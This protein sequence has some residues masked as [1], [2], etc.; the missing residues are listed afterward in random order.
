MN[1]IVERLRA[2]QRQYAW[3]STGTPVQASVRDDPLSQEAADEIENRRAEIRQRAIDYLA[4]DTEARALQHEIERLR[5]ERDALKADAER[6]RWLK[7]N[8]VRE[9]NL[10]D[11]CIEYHCDFEHWNDL[12]ASIDAARQEQKP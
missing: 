9:K 12:D 4:L 10:G 11:K 7:A 2:V 3:S 1:D 5:A 6:Y 8:A